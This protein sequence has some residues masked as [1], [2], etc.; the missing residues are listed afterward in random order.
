MIP[1]T[2]SSFP[3]PPPDSTR[4]PRRGISPRKLI[5]GFILACSILFFFLILFVTAVAILR[6]AA[7]AGHSGLMRHI[8][9]IGRSIAHHMHH[10]SSH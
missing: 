10:S 4:F 3:P 1:S 7:P 5:L 9:A 6:E 2:P 8:I